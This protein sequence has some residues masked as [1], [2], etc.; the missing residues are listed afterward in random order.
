MCHVESIINGRPITV[1]S[2]DVNDQELL[3]PSHL[4][5]LRASSA[6]PYD[7]FD[8]SEVY[9]KRPWRQIHY[10]ASVFWESWIREYLPTLQQR[11]NWVQP[12]RSLTVGDIVLVIDESLPRNCWL[13]GRIVEIYRGHDQLVKSVQVKMKSSTLVRPVRK[14]GL[15]ESVKKAEASSA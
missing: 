6:L 5:L 9:S 12:T 3:T 10:L 13:L 2:N 8:K 1:V 7:N 14:L 11:Q 4:L 15:L